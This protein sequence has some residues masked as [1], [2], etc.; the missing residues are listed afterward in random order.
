MVL[1]SSDNLY[2]GLLARRGIDYRERSSE[3]FLAEALEAE[4]TAKQMGPFDP[5]AQR[6]YEQSRRLMEAAALAEKE[7]R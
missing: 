1:N 4:Q 5:Y 6:F 2:A 3:E 7:G